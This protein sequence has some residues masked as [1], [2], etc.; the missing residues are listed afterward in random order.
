MVNSENGW[1]S[2]AP[3]T[4]QLQELWFYCHFKN[5]PEQESRKVVINCYWSLSHGDLLI[6]KPLNCYSS[7]K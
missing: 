6:A 2:C 3:Y 7:P 5:N 1:F 4:A